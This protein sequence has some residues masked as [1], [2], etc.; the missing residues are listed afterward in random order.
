MQ[1]IYSEIWSKYDEATLLPENEKVIALNK[2]LAELENIS[3]DKRNDEYFYLKGFVN[4]MKD[5]SDI[6]LAKVNFQ[7]A[8]EIDPLESY[9]RS[10]LGHCLYDLGDYKEADIIF[11]C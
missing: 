3:E 5:P 4:Y 2:I 6:L 9:A 7:K 1:K 8:L 10:Y 11:Y